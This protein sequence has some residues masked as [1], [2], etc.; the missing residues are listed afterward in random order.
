MTDNTKKTAKEIWKDARVFVFGSAA[1]IAGCVL[2]V[3]YVNH[4]LKY[5]KERFKNEVKKEVLQE[6]R[7]QQETGVYTNLGKIR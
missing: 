4:A 1:V 3:I 5:E 2:T 7:Q 6:L